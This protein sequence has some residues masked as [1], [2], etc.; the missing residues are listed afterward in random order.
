[1]VDWASVR[2]EYETKDLSTRQI[3]KNF[4]V[5]EAAVRKQAKKDGWKKLEKGAQPPKSRSRSLIVRPER[6]EPSSPVV[7]S[8]VEVAADVDPEELAKEG[9]LVLKMLLAE[10]KA[11]GVH[12]GWL[13]TVIEEETDGDKTPQR[14][15]ALMKAV[16]APVRTQAAKNIA[17]ALQTLQALGPGKKAAAKNAAKGI[18]TGRFATP[19]PPPAFKF[20]TVQ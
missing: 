17:L 9:I 20:D 18:A 12:I 11:E 15:K 1:M 10:I 14:Y 19:P 3:A 4:N 8:P 6:A 5:S 13:E 16:S 2:N 7:S